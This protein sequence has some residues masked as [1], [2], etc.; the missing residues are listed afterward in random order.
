MNPCSQADGVPVRAVFATTRWTVVLAAGAA[1]DSSPQVAAALEQLCRAYWYPLYAFVRRRG[2]APHDA[3]DLTQGFFRRLLEK[4]ALGA[5]NPD[6][7]RFRSFLLASL[8]HFLANEWDRLRAQKRGGALP[9]LEL[10][11]LSAETRYRL[12]PADPRADADALYDRQWALALL[13]QVLAC[14]RAEFAT[15]GNEAQF[16]K[17][18]T[19]LTAGRGEIPYAEAAA[20]LGVSEGAL[21]VAVHRLRKRYRDL[22]REEIAQTVA[23]PA[24][25]E[26]ELAA[27]FRAL[28]G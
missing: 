4:G 8:K 18:K 2:W 22:L 11:A 6:K 20:R 17:M 12:E 24:E 26:D 15:A 25:V 1:N 13:E 23:S 28:S 19:F 9:H 27:L 10:D 16:E 3:E 21:R 5:A 14:L 7:G